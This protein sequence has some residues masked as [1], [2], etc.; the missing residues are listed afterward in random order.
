MSQLGDFIFKDGRARWVVPVN[1]GSCQTDR[2][3]LADIAGVIPER[4]YQINLIN[5]AVDA[6]LVQSLLGFLSSV[7]VAREYFHNLPRR[8]GMQTHPSLYAHHWPLHAADQ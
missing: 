8:A 7:G 6:E 4:S 3:I 5:Q 1:P 2:R